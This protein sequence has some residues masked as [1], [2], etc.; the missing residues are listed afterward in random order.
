MMDR[1]DPE[2]GEVREQD[3]GRCGLG[4]IVGRTGWGGLGFP[5]FSPGTTPAF[6]GLASVVI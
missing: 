4:S 3:R 6:N 5:P 2:R 1:G